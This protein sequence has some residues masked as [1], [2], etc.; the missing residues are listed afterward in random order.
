MPGLG[1]EWAAFH[2]QTRKKVKEKERK[3]RKPAVTS[4]QLAGLL[5][6]DQKEKQ[7]QFRMEQIEIAA[8][9]LA[10]LGNE[11]AIKM[12]PDTPNRFSGR[13]RSSRVSL[14]ADEDTKLSYD[15]ELEEGEIDERM[16]PVKQEAHLESTQ[17]APEGFAFLTGVDCHN[18]P[19]QQTDETA[20]TIIVKMEP[21]THTATGTKRRAEELEEGR[22]VVKKER[23]ED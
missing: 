7:S 21:T 4:Q 13:V 20:Y 2:A 9:L 6:D 11:N 15:S 17:R 12:E 5:G 3:K 18:K 16:L 22:I 14:V 8:Q 1:L 19:I 10:P 23:L